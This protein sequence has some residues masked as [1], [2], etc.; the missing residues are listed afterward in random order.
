MDFG[1][2]TVTAAGSNDIFLVTFGGMPAEPEIIDIV[3]VGNDQG[4]KVR[5]QVARSGGDDPAAVKP[6]SAYEAY[7]RIDPLPLAAVGAD[8]RATLES[9]T[10]S[11]ALLPPG[12]WEFAASIPAH[13]EDE[14]FM[15]TPTLADST[16]TSGQHYS[17]FFIRAATG[18]PSLY[19]DS[20]PD[21]GYSLDNL[22]P[23]IP[24]GFAYSAG[25]LT[26]NESTATD[27][28]YFSVYGSNTNSF[29]SAT[30]I[31]YTVA[32]E[33]DITASPY[34]YYFA[35]ATDF[36]GN[37]GKPAATSAV[38]DV[39]ETPKSYVLSIS[40]YPSP[41]LVSL[42]LTRIGVRHATIINRRAMHTKPLQ[43]E[44]L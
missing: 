10:D 32:P 28:D 37:E 6:I 36:S 40:S 7:R 29:A 21:S 19:Y 43:A 16:L 35:T 27:F 12:D 11:P 44:V 15:V 5:I 1:G 18:T 8:D 14:Y 30:L 20:L 25:Q 42:R 2:G 31:D 3:D 33:M 9:G 26:W 41:L 13:A 34:T 17:V 38:S 39:G 4:R 23:G 24:G 22:A